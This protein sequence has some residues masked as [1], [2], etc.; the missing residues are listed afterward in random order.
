MSFD[1]KKLGKD[2]ANAALDRKLSKAEETYIREQASKGAYGL[3]ANGAFSVTDQMDVVLQDIGDGRLDEKYQRKA[4]IRGIWVDNHL[5]TLK[6]EFSRSLAKSLLEILMD[7]NKDAARTAF[8][9]NPD[10]PA[11]LLESTRYMSSFGAEEED[12][13]EFHMRVLLSYVGDSNPTMHDM[14]VQTIHAIASTSTNYAFGHPLS[15]DLAKIIVDPQETALR[16]NAALRATPDDQRSKALG[17]LNSHN[18]GDP[19]KSLDGFYDSSTI[20]KTPQPQ[21]VRPLSPGE[22]VK[23]R[24][25]TVEKEIDKGE[26]IKATGIPTAEGNV[27]VG[28]GVIAEIVSQDQDIYTVKFSGVTGGAWLTNYFPEARPRAHYSSYGLSVKSLRVPRS[29]LQPLF[30]EK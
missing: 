23:F 9:S 20:S 4:P 18:L 3:E 22:F 5:I 14:A 19:S 21:D 16:R 29:A 12:Y 17:F 26:T 24:L 2:L 25:S 10:N 28:E 30:P 11:R 15:R 7:P 8:L 13:T 1:A 6:R 27:Y